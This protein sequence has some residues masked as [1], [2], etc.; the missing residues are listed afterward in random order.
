MID[1]LQMT[2]EES[3]ASLWSKQLRFGPKGGYQYRCAH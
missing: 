3:S 1:L 2:G